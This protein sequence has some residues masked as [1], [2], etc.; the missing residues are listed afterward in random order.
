MDDAARGAGVKIT[1]DSLWM[2][3]SPSGR[4]TMVRTLQQ[5]TVGSLGCWP[6]NT[7]P[8]D[9][10]DFDQSQHDEEL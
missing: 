5:N 9:P 7:A 2:M 4:T 8:V 6:A 10:Y 3:R 1:R